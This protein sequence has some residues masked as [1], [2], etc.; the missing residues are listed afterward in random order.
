MMVEVVVVVQGE[1]MEVVVEERLVM[2]GVEE[3]KEE[4]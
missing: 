2:V 1:V 3:E 4:E